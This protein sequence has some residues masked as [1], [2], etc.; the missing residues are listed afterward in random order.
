[1]RWPV[2]QGKEDRRAQAAPQAQVR[3]LGFPLRVLV[4][5]GR[6][7]KEGVTTFLPCLIVSPL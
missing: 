5:Y 7:L 2:G 4:S 3:S 6:V 1:M